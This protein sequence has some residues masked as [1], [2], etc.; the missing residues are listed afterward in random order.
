MF[1]ADETEASRLI[2]ALVPNDLGLLE[3]RVA[4][5][6]TSENLVWNFVAKV[7]TKDPEV[8]CSNKKQK[9]LLIDKLEVGEEDKYCCTIVPLLK[10]RVFPS[11]TSSSS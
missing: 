4:T 1:E 5:E 9:Q 8:L 7:T 3:G 6:C 2:G 11:L 10:S